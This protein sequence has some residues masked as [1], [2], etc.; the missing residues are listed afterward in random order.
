MARV[1]LLLMGDD[2]LRAAFQ[3]AIQRLEEA[4]ARIAQLEQAQAELRAELRSAT[5]EKEQLERRLVETTTA[6]AD[7]QREARRSSLGDERS[8]SFE[9]GLRR[10]KTEI[11][12]GP[13]LGI[14]SSAPERS[15]EGE[16]DEEQATA[17][18]DVAQ[19]RENSCDD[20]VEG[21][22]TTRE[23]VEPALRARLEV[24]EEERDC[25]LSELQARDESCRQLEARLEGR[26]SELQQAMG[27][28]RHYEKRYREQSERVEELRS[29]IARAE[30]VRDDNAARARRAEQAMESLQQRLEETSRALV[31]ALERESAQ[32]ARRA[33]LFEPRVAPK[34]GAVATLHRHDDASSSNGGLSG[35]SPDEEE[36]DMPTI[37]AE[38][39][40]SGDLATVFDDSPPTL[41]DE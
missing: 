37:A 41:D 24:V 36:P 12:Q 13:Q 8:V 40:D 9:L 27:R 14:S 20:S 16:P 5:L 39:P 29:E 6:M 19:I 18:F 26:E 7:V 22:E 34:G 15:F 31:T 30:R 17:I 3:N 10:Q 1:S 32:R 23:E 25:L 21:E 4:Q 38:I 11:F 28:A 35:F 33:S 2:S